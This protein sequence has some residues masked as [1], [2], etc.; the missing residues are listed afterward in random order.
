[1]CTALMCVHVADVRVQTVLKCVC[2]ALMF[3]CAGSGGFSKLGA[4]GEDIHG[5]H[6]IRSLKENREK[7]CTTE[8]WI[9][10]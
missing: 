2:T 1:M 4:Q 6:L 10:R 7:K 9:G 8:C 3:V 5:A